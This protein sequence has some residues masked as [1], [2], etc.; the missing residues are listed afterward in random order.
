[1]GRA[2]EDQRVLRHVGRACRN[3]RGGRD[4]VL[5]ASLDATVAQA[6]AMKTIRRYVAVQIFWSTALVFAALLL[7]FGFFDFIQELGD[8]GRGRYRL[9]L[10]GLVL[11]LSLSGRGLQTTSAGGP[12]RP[13]VLLCPQSFP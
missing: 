3:A 10:A 9:S 13:P 6:Q 4:D 12:D 5:F 11:F 1:M 7:L 2:A 8:I